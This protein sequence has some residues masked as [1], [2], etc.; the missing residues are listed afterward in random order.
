[1]HKYVVALSELWRDKPEQNTPL[2][3]SDN[4]K[5]VFKQFDLFGFDLSVNWEM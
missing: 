5:F 3:L 1:M 2:T 4:T